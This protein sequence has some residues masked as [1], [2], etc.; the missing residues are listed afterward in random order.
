MG[1]SNEELEDFVFFETGLIPY[2][3]NSVEI[4][5]LSNKEKYDPNFKSLARVLIKRIT[6]HGTTI[7][8]ASDCIK[9][10]DGWFAPEKS[11]MPFKC[12]EG[13]EPNQDNSG[14][15]DCAAGTFNPD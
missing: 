8:G 1:P 9:V 13:M 2:G 5:V 7:G 4:S 6:F 10:L 3:N 11:V 12:A 14:C 15:Q